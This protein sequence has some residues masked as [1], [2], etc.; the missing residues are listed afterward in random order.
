[1]RK[2][3]LLAAISLQLFLAMTS[4]GW[5]QFGAALS[6][7]LLVAVLRLPQDTSHE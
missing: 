2:G 1:M 4:T 3:V 7:F 5:W 6:A